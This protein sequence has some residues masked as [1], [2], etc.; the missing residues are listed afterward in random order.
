MAGQEVLR[1]CKEIDG[2]AFRVRAVFF[3]R[4][5]PLVPYAHFRGVLMIAGRKSEA[6][7]FA[8]IPHCLDLIP[9]VLRAEMPTR[10]ASRDI[11]VSLR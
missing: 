4:F 7:V 6:K 8:A 10:N 1:R 5:P 9:F 2:A 3:A 11:F